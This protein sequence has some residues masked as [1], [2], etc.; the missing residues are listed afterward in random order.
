MQKLRRIFLFLFFFSYWVIAN[1]WIVD[2]NGGGDFVDIQQAVNNSTQ[3]DTLFV[4]NG[5]YSPFEV[6][7]VELT[8][9]GQSR[10][11]TIVSGFYGGCTISSAKRFEINNI[12]F[13]GQLQNGIWA[14]MYSRYESIINLPE[15]VI[16][17]CIFDSKR[18]EDD[19][20]TS[21]IV[22][23][24]AYDQLLNNGALDSLAKRIKIVNN[25]F[26]KK[27]KPIVLYPGGIL[28]KRSADTASCPIL[29]FNCR[30]NYYGL[31]DSLSI[32]S[33]IRDDR[34]P[35]TIDTLYQTGDYSNRVHFNFKPW[36][37]TLV[38]K[39]AITL[40]GFQYN[41]FL[42]CDSLFL[43]E[44]IYPGTVQSMG[45]PLTPK[46]FELIKT[47]PNPFNNS[48]IIQFSLK[49]HTRVNL[50]IY[51]ISGHLINR[52][53]QDKIMAPGMHGI[54]WHGQ[55]STGLAVSSGVYVV[56][57]KTRNQSVTHKLLLIK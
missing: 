12:R 14:D 26:V 57:L 28:G 31:F 24:I 15:L 33:F 17:N 51:N 34:D 18:S 16:R 1:T 2:A 27:N 54:A 20:K 49:N 48:T 9:I 47:Y 11:S 6:P 13:G 10:D 37:D 3:G 43:S 55:N 30:N 4:R 7:S 41:N 53:I 5:V 42:N 38:T 25:T 39:E 45:D 36:S 46:N 56:I 19:P 22:L 40:A 21:G 52:L 29:T 50:E 44:L 35:V 32:K 23:E 8:I